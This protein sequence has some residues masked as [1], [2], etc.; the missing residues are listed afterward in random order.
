MP[1]L[2]SQISSVVFNSTLAKENL[3]SFIQFLIKSALLNMANLPC[4]CSA[5]LYLCPSVGAVW[6]FAHVPSGL[7]PWEPP[8]APVELGQR[9]WCCF[10]FFFYPKFC[11]VG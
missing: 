9:W 2:P 1:G 10:T 8:P 11:I 6:P 3:S 7:S 4:V 5:V